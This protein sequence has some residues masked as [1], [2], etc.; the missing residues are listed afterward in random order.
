M[1]QLLHIDAEYK[2]WIQELSQRYRQ[3]QIKA[4]VRVNSEMLRFYWSVG[5]DI[6]E[7]QFD[8]KYGSH[9]YENLSSDLSSA[10][11]N[12]TGFSPT[13]LHYAKHFF[14]LYAPLFANLQQLAENFTQ[15]IL[16]QPAE[17]FRDSNRQQLADDFE[18]LFCI[19]W[20]H[21]QR[22]IDK[23]KG[24]SQKAL[25]FARKTWENQ[26]GRGMLVNFLDTDLYEREGKALSN[27]SS[28]LPAA[29]SD[30]AQQL[31]KDPYHF[32]FLQLTEK[33][34]EKE[35]KGELINK[36]SQFLL[37]LGK[38]FSFV[39]REFRLSAGG[40][41]KFIDLL[42]YIIPLH[43][44]CVI[45][46]K[47]TEFDF[48]D[49]GQLAGYTAMVDDLLNTPNDNPS[50]GLLICKERNAVL[51]R[52]ALSRTSAPIGISKYELAQQQLPKDVQSVLPSVEE[53]ENELNNHED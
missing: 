22:I 43:R 17:N 34:S 50:I 31:I 14:A 46:V 33:Y 4:S 29:D 16:Q 45:E 20:S 40:K 30:F 49:I 51:A 3:S 38:G 26:W 2:Q 36:L 41:D 5:K 47:I 7:R 35:L 37:E 9:F 32:E 21:H 15:P 1:S 11:G 52:Y 8:N 27:F 39:G 23:V 6:A 53:I 10:L 42:F 19:P 25:F 28:A 12:K 13:S 48:Q 44:Y 18:L 24:D